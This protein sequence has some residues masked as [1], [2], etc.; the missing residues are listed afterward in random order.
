M[1]DTTP[2]QTGDINQDAT[3]TN[4]H[5][6]IIQLYWDLLISVFSSQLKLPIPISV[7]HLRPLAP[8]ATNENPIVA[9]T[10]EWVPDIGNRKDVAISNHAALPP[11]M[12]VVFR[13]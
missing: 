13:V 3:V 4:I 12:K 7:D 1:T 6:W 8:L 11:A 9:P 2:E 5:I 10:I